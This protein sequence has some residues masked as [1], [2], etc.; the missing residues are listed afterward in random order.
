V[1]MHDGSVGLSPKVSRRCTVV[2]AELQS[3]S[4]SHLFWGLPGHRLQLGSG[5]QLSDRSMWQRKAWWAGVSSG[6]LATYPNSELRW[7][8]IGSITGLKS[9]REETSVFHT[10]SCQRILVIWLWH[11]MWK[12]SGRFMSVASRDQVWQAYVRHGISLP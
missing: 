11:F 9:V 12:A 1:S 3:W 6:S 7:R 4:S 10:W 2:P 8:T 5:R